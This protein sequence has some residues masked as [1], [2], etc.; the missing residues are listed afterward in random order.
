MS[1]R[2]KIAIIAGEESG[3]LLGADLIVALRKTHDVELVGVGGPHLASLGLKSLFDPTEIALMGVT[4]ILKSLPRL[5]SLIG[6]TS[7]Y[8][9]NEKPDCLIVIDS[10]EFC[11]RVAK[12][13]CKAAPHIPIINYVCPSVWAWRPQRAKAMKG[14]IDHILAILPFEPQFLNGLDGPPATYVGHPAA[15]NLKFLEATASQATLEKKR[16]P[17]GEKQLLI[18]PGSRRGEV[19]RSLPHMGSAVQILKER[20]HTVGL[21]LPTLPHLDA[22]VREMT[23]DWAVKPQI[24]TDASVKHT[25]FACADAAL[26]ASGTV[27]LELALCTV[28]T[29]AIYDMDRLARILVR[30]MHTGWTASLPN[31]IAD[32]PVVV[33]YYND[34]IRPAMLARQIER[35]IVPG[36][37]RSAQ[38]EG[39]RRIR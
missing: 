13:V 28:P 18:L 10:P 33:E 7:T 36:H 39:F 21:L 12:K 24:T 23:A 26:A 32:E 9:V 1:G 6:K 8:I 30:Y 22:L 3:D 38:R 5:F 19:T 4:A 27:T 15:Q 11:Q 17:G 14:Y 35:I 20:G 37:A 2:L 31:L 34:Q 29:V 16:T 25:M